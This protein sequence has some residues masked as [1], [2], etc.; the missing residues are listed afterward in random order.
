MNVDRACRICSVAPRAATALAAFGAALAAF[1]ASAQPVDAR[2]AYP[3]KPVRVII[4]LA[5]GGASDTQARLFAHKLTESMGRPFVVDNR[6]GASGTIAYMAV[7]KSPPDGY[8]L[9]AAAAGHSTTPIFFPKLPYDPVKDFAPISLVV[10]APFLLVVH[11]SVPARSAKDLVALALARPGMLD[12]GSAGHGTATG[13]ALEMFRI[14]AGV[15]I[16]HVPYKGISQATIDT[17]AGQVHGLFSNPL[18]SL[19]YVKAGRL[20]ALAVT[21]ARRSLVLPELPTVAESGVPGYEAATW[22]GWLAP[23]GTPAA[24]V[25]RLNA[26][27]A[28]GARAPDVAGKLAADGGEPVGSTPEEFSRFLVT[29]I[30]R[31]RKVVRESGMALEQ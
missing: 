31:W 2:E 20:R 29:D 6:A 1:P 22:H 26:E 25:N 5:P 3:A 30:A 24:I 13:L 16:T 10:Q 4:G 28:K 27:L 15:K 17:L 11:P 21:S 9:L 23:A 19:S 18:S 7:A 8:T 14:M 12:F